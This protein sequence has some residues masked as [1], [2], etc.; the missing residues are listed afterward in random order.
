MP[1]YIS[2]QSGL[3]SDPATWGGGGYPNLNGDIF[4]IAANHVVTYDLVTG[5]STGYD[6]SIIS[7][8]LVH[9]TGTN[10]Q[11]RMNGFI[12]VAA[13]GRYELVDG[14]TVIFRGTNSDDHGIFLNGINTTFLARGTS[15]IAECNLSASGEVGDPYIVVDS[16][17]LFNTGDWLS[18]FYR[19]T[20]LKSR[21][22]FIAETGYPSWVTS[23][24]EWRAENMH[25]TDEGFIVH[26]ISGNFIYPRNLVGPEA[27]ITFANNNII[28]VNNSK[29]FR[30]N[31]SIIFGSGDTR[32][33]S[34]ISGIDYPNH[35]IYLNNNITSNNVTG[36]TVYLGALVFP[37]QSG[38]VVRR[39]GSQ[40]LTTQAA[41]ST[42]ITVSSTNDFVSGDSFY[43]EYNDLVTNTWDQILTNDASTWSGANRNARHVVSAVSGNVLTFSPALILSARAGA[44]I[45][46]A[47]R[48]ITI[49]TEDNTHR[50]YGIQA[51]NTTTTRTIQGASRYGR[52]MI[53][54]DVE[55]IGLATSSSS[56]NYALYI[57]G[58]FH[59]GHFDL[60][61]T[62][63][64]CVI[65]GNGNT[66]ATYAHRLDNTNYQI[67]RNCVIVN[68]SRGSYLGNAGNS[69]YNNAIINCFRSTENTYMQNH[70]SFYMFNRA[71][72][73][74][75]YEYIRNIAHLNIST[76]QN[77]YMGEYGPLLVNGFFYQNHYVFRYHYMRSSSRDRTFLE[78]NKFDHTYAAGDVTAQYT[79]GDQSRDIYRY[80][81]EISNI[82]S[83]S[84]NYEYDS[85][86]E[87][88]PGLRYW[89]S[90]ENAYRYIGTN[91]AGTRDPEGFFQSIVLPPNSKLTVIAEAKLH[92]DNA[93]TNYTFRPQLIIAPFLSNPYTSND[94]AKVY[95]HQFNSS[96][97]TLISK[98][99]NFGAD[100][101]YNYDSA[102]TSGNYQITPFNSKTE[103]K[104]G[105]LVYNNTLPYH[106]VVNIG[107]CCISNNARA[108]WYE[109]PLII[110]IDT[111]YAN[112]QFTLQN[113]FW[114][115]GLSD[116][117]TGP[118]NIIRLGNARFT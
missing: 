32:T 35:T 33:T 112:S 88:G 53:L 67:K 116:L 92:P 17:S 93:N 26:D 7:G 54:K 89:D 65:D 86:Y 78:Y 94:T 13:G 82:I 115:V 64:G 103:Y 40:I 76:Y 80:T 101:V 70:N 57:Q 105:T 106:I 3:F 117:Q 66:N 38:S 28:Q 42:T 51:S 90:S 85:V 102:A 72:R 12:E 84:H 68:Y 55:F 19:Y 63:E 114:K 15:V 39:V 10:T 36:A 30:L 31:Q 56:Y 43:V 18:V 118:R 22:A 37:H 50:A 110:Q 48:N 60:S 100:G 95:S 69:H 74:W 58:G 21:D 83:Y 11:L 45:Y 111:P 16:G 104:T 113:S 8:A 44:F 108:G 81:T 24:N 62:I 27:T 46:K 14:T 1:T 49:R 47:N 29:V 34:T 4:R 61:H 5:V 75:D 99:G 77:Y 20:D 96:K 25:A 79:V 91:G 52:K 23:S 41:G 97:T 2:T 107:L 71:S 98:Q 9:L 109:K 59:D 73:I 87:F 6:N